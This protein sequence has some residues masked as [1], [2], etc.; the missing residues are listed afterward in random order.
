V[1]SGFR[2]TIL[3]GPSGVGKGTV[4]AALR[5]QHPEVWLSISATTRTPRP[6]EVH[7]ENYYFV[8]DEEFDELIELG[9]LLEWAAYGSN[10][11]GTPAAPVRA[12]IADGRA[13]LLELDLAGVRQARDLLDEAQT[14]LIAPPSWDELE[15][16]LAS[17]GTET[18][19]VRARRLAIAEAELAAADEFDR[20]IVNDEVE[21][22][23]EE[24]VEF[25]GLGASEPAQPSPETNE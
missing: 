15:R 6:R 22:T 2:P 7:G 12:A 16:R 21:R 9:G 20:V 23:V 8:S 1:S 14:V 18:P 10:R 17:R 19:E 25:M 24:L 3:A 11:Y 5:A 4:I 13:V